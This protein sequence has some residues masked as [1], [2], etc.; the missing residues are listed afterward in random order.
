MEGA[1][2]NTL[3]KV[4][5]AKVSPRSQTTHHIRDAWE[6]ITLVKLLLEVLFW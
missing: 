5:L 2:D 3:F 4:L 6:Q 1:G